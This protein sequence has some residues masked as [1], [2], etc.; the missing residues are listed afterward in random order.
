MKY[1]AC[2]DQHYDANT[3]TCSQVVFVEIPS[4]SILPP[5]TIGEGLEVSAAIVGVLGVAFVIRLASK[6][7]WSARA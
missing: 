6:V 3:G 1:A 4:S 2:L 5:M 7:A